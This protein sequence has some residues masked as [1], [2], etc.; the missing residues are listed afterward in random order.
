MDT[1]A[2][3]VEDGWVVDILVAWGVLVVHREA[4]KD[5]KSNNGPENNGND[6][7]N[8]AGRFSAKNRPHFIHQRLSHRASHDDNHHGQASIFIEW[9]ASQAFPTGTRLETSKPPPSQT[10]AP[11]A[12]SPPGLQIVELSLA[13]VDPHI[14]AD[15]G[16]FG[17]LTVQ[18]YLYYQAFPNDRWFTKCLVYTIYSIQVVQIVMTTIDAFRN[19]RI[20][21]WRRF[22]ADEISF[23]V[24]SFYAF[25]IY[26]LSSSRIIP[27]I[28]VGA[29]LALSVSAFITGRFT[30]EAGDVTVLNN[31][32]DSTPLGV[33]LSGAALIDIA[34]A[35]C[36]IYY[37]PASAASAALVTLILYFV[38]PGKVYYAAPAN[39][40]PML[41]AN[42]M[43][44]VLNS[45]FQF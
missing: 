18:L 38:F 1:L 20:R 11:V 7:I 25:R 31:R 23:I 34:I 16:L 32:R 8:Q 6:A 44:A 4:V 35:G 39:L 12:T 3:K 19:L 17:A 27:I 13:S 26:V 40:M 14:M 36:M 10:M 15:W 9:T 29:S 37:F 22:G 28:I 24:Q 2:S 21:L 42:T 43:S 41:Y 5:A 45:R 30:L 33:Y